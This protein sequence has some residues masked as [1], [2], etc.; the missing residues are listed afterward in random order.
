M[1]LEES[2]G[3]EDHGRARRYGEV[4]DRPVREAGKHAQCRTARHLH[5]LHT[6][7]VT[8]QQSVVPG[9]HH[10]GRALAGC[11]GETDEGGE[12]LA[13]DA[14]GYEEFLQPGHLFGARDTAEHQRA[15]GDPRRDTEGGLVGA[16]PG[17]VTDHR[18]DRA[19]DALHDVVEVTA[20][21]RLRAPGTVAG[22]RFHARAAQQGPGQQSAFQAG[23]LL[24]LHT[25]GLEG[26]CRPLGLLALD[27]VAHRASEQARFDP[28]L[29][30]VVLRAGGDGG[31]SGLLLGESG[32]DHDSGPF[33]ARPYPGERLQPLGVRQMQVEQDTVGY[34]G[35]ERLG[36]LGHRP[37]PL[38][39]YLQRAVGDQFLHQQRVTRVVL[40]QQDGGLPGHP[41]L[42]PDPFSTHRQQ[43]V[44]PWPWHHHGPPHRAD[45]RELSC[46]Q[47]TVESIPVR[48]DVPYADRHQ[49][50]VGRTEFGP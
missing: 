16:V 37:H 18:V 32:E 7:A 47:T 36:C 38:Q 49:V 26:D 8:H 28:A 46:R 24:G 6:A 48:P 20:Q 22:H 21:Q 31:E 12:D 39:P 35:C 13:A 34:V 11:G 42:G 29:D 3:E 23:V 15:P 50:A 33:G 19:V 9:P 25:A 45:S 2:V 1:P 14:L 5:P 41:G 43:V 27:R 44:G 4:R 10:A 40:D 17:D 30:Q